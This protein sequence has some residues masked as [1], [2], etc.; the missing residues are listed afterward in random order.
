[1]A[2]FVYFTGPENTNLREHPAF[3]KWCRCMQ[4]SNNEACTPDGYTWPIGYIMPDT[5]EVKLGMGC[6]TIMRKIDNCKCM[7]VV[8]INGGGI[9]HDLV[10]QIAYALHGAAPKSVYISDWNGDLQP[11]YDISMLVPKPTEDDDIED[12]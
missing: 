12:D 8:P 2:G 3:I 7:V 5:S 11:I 9:E 1:M 6:E 4:E 10:W